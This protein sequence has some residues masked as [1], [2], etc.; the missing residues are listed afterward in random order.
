MHVEQK[1]KGIFLPK[2]YI[3]IH[4]ESSDESV[5]SE[6]ASISDEDD[7]SIRRFP[8]FEEGSRRELSLLEFIISYNIMCSLLTTYRIWL[9]NVDTNSQQVM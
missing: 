3:S 1:T 4:D 2:L 7:I 5:V 6:S 9:D 8:F